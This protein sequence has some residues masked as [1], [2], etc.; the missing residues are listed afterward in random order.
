MNKICFRDTTVSVWEEK[1]DEADFRSRVF[2]PALIFLGRRGWKVSICPDTKRRW[3][4]LSK[5]TRIAQKGELHV[6]IETRGRHFEIEIWQDLYNRSRSDSGRWEFDKR[7]RMPYLLGRRCDLE[8]QK[9]VAFLQKKTG[10]PV[11]NNNPILGNADKAIQHRIKTTGHYRPE[12]GHASFSMECNRTSADK[13]TLKHGQ[14]VWT[15]DRKG[16]VIRGKAFYSLN[17][18]WMVRTSHDDFTYRSAG[19][20]WV[21]APSN[22]R[23]KRNGESRRKVLEGLLSSA[24][25]R[26]DFQRADQIKNLLFGKDPL[27]RIWSKKHEA[28]Y[29]P[30]ACGYTS[31]KS[32]AGLYRRDEA[33]RLTSHTD[34]LTIRPVYAGEMAA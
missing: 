31:D 29:R 27:F 22:L 12:L 18:Q 28:Y 13:Q 8:M 14:T 20:L 26:M 33:E 2:I 23:L 9:L 15:T 3:P 17:A 19:E 4:S 32:A 7:R 10:Y 25:D 11:E 5:N 21:A 6:R 1:V 34:S 30:N 24:I 16:R